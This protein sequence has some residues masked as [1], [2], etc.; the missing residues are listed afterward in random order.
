MM[1]FM[2]ELFICKDKSNI[3]ENINITVTEQLWSNYD[4]V[5]YKVCTHVNTI[6]NFF[7]FMNVF[8]VIEYA[9]IE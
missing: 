8:K 7:M 4:A 3:E 2:Q 6:S 9:K 5:N 1:Q